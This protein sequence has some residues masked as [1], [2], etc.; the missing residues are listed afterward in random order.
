ME[1]RG[2]KE[3]CEGGWNKKGEGFAVVKVSFRQKSSVLGKPSAF[4][5]CSNFAGN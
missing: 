3:A 1:T 4:K 2:R 5:R